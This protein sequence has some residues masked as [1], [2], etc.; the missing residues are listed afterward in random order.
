MIHASAEGFGVQVVPN[1]EHLW[2]P[3][4]GTKGVQQQLGL[5]FYV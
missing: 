5:G 2:G 1:Q 3:L 4:T